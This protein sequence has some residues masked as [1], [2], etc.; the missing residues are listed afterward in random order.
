MVWVDS[1]TILDVTGT[2]YMVTPGW[3]VCAEIA[4]LRS[5]LLPQQGLTYTQLQHSVV[6]APN[7]YT[8]YQDTDLDLAASM[9]VMIVTQELAGGPI[10]IRHQ[11]TTDVNDGS[12]YYED[13]VGVNFDNIAYTMKAII[14]PYIGQRNATP[15]VVEELDVRIKTTLDAFKLAPAGFQ[16]IGPAILGWDN[17]TVAIDQTFRDRIITGATVQMPLP[18]NIVD[19]TLYGTTLNGDVSL[20]T[21]NITPISNNS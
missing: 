15:A 16:E 5:A 17:L 9:G 21:T 6:A 11:L 20:T 18:L 4:G 8:V 13:S 2:I 19:A 12:L 14:Q 7:M 1:P 3:N 10:F